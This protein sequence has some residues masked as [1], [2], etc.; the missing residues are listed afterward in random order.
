MFK[1]NLAVST[2]HRKLVKA[3]SLFTKA[4]NMLQNR[5]YKTHSVNL[6]PHRFKH[7]FTFCHTR[8]VPFL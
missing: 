6:Y 1:I 5:F 2:V 8:T 4:Q 3:Y 7:Y